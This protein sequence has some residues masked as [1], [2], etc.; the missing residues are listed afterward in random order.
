MPLGR[1][2]LPL[3]AHRYATPRPERRADIVELLYI[4]VVPPVMPSGGPPLKS[5]R[6]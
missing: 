6:P 3:Q 2:G 4:L 5:C 1:V